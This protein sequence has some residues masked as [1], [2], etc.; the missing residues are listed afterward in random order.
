MIRCLVYRTSLVTWL[1]VTE[2][3]ESKKEFWWD[4]NLLQNL[5]PNIQYII[6]C[7]VEYAYQFI[8][9][10]CNYPCKTLLPLSILSPP[11]WKIILVT[12][13]KCEVLQL[14]KCLMMIKAYETKI[15]CL[16][17]FSAFS[18]WLLPWKNLHNVGNRYAFY[19]CFFICN[20][21]SSLETV[22]P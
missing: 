16:L 13:S 15:S 6:C 1:E 7:Y 4:V 2:G 5:L 11:V 20:H 3:W 17:I 12:C 22:F 18:E 9:S 14:Q 19:N 8:L 10:P 21:A